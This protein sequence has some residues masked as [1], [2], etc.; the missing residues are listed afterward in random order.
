MLVP[1]SAFLL[2]HCCAFPLKTLID[3]VDPV[4]GVQMNDVTTASEMVNVSVKM[5]PSFFCD[6]VNISAGGLNCAL[7]IDSGFFCVHGCDAFLVNGNECVAFGTE[8]AALVGQPIGTRGFPIC[9]WK[10]L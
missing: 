2:S 7:S 5:K 1:V 4:H 6:L 3:A 9:V 10:V 8:R